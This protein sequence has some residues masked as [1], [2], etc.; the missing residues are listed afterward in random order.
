VCLAICGDGAFLMHGNEVSTAEANGVAAIWVVLDNND[1]AMVSQGMNQFFP[2]KS[3][4]WNDYYALGTPDVA[5]FARSLGADAYEVRSVEDM[6]HALGA[7]INASGVNGK[8]QV[9][10]VHIDPSQIPPYYQDI[11]PPVHGGSQ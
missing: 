10:A 7:A 2:D 3:G 9:I 5:Q 4:I 6:Q 8:P 11:K 1:L